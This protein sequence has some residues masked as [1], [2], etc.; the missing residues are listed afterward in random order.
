MYN[1]SAFVLFVF[2]LICAAI[3]SQSDAAF[4]R[5]E[6]TDMANRNALLQTASQPRTVPS[7]NEDGADKPVCVDLHDT[8][9]T[10]DTLIE[11]FLSILSSSQ[12]IASLP[13][14]RNARKMV[15]AST[16]LAPTPARS[17][18]QTAGPRRG[19]HRRQPGLTG[20][21]TIAGEPK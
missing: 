8:L 14:E 2:Q 17:S 19:I 13:P 4:S 12:G 18:W 20:H 7:V 11:S 1:P 9:I 3:P 15:V 10:T 5:A 21:K 16:A 6:L